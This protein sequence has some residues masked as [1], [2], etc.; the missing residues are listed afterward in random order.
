MEK[1]RVIV[2]EN[3]PDPV[4][5][6]ICSVSREMQTYAGLLLIFSSSVKAEE[7]MA[8]KKMN[9]RVCRPDLRSWNGIVSELQT[10]KSRVC[11]AVLDQCLDK[12][13]SSQLFK[14]KLQ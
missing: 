13:R 11:L 9:R 6:I 7:F 14:I 3:T 10:K 4:W 8:V 1:K 12:S 2:I 5:V